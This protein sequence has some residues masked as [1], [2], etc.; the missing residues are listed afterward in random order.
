QNTNP[1]ANTIYID[2]MTNGSI[3]FKENSLQSMM[4]ITQKYNID[5]LVTPES[6]LSP[7]NNLLYNLEYTYKIITYTL[8]LTLISVLIINTFA[9]EIIISRKKKL[10]AIGFLNGKNILFS[11]KNN[12]ILYSI[13]S[14]V[15]VCV[16]YLMNKF[17]VEILLV[18]IV[19]Y[20][21]ICLY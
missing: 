8:A 5:K 6:K 19:L 16:M 3:F 15:S 21:Y 18:I 7:Y 11:M 13:I 4:D 20:L 9:A 2:K 12:F 1:Y 14:I 17:T 10:I